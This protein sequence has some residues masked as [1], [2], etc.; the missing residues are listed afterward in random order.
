MS[1]LLHHLISSVGS[2]TI[3]LA[4]ANAPRGSIYVELLIQRVKFTNTL[5]GSFGNGSTRLCVRTVI[6]VSHFVFLLFFGLYRS[7]GGN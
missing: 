6:L 1:L 4:G 2:F 7:I 5:S 3:V